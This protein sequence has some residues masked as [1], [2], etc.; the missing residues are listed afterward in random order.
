MLLKQWD[1]VWDCPSP[2][3]WPLFHMRRYVTSYMTSI[4]RPL[5]VTVA[6]TAWKVIGK[7]LF[8]VERD[9]AQGEQ[10]L[11]FLS[12]NPSP[13]QGK[14]VHDW[15]SVHSKHLSS[16]KSVS[17]AGGNQFLETMWNLF[18]SSGKCVKFHS[19][20]LHVFWP[21]HVTGPSSYIVAQYLLW[22][23]ELQPANGLCILHNRVWRSRL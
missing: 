15:A 1:I 3:T 18:G 11:S 12:K 13:Q 2:G 19:L 14:A 22:N 9:C 23:Y 17:T 4:S 5:Q 7:Y 20:D 21:E 10:E 6:K 16:E 8:H